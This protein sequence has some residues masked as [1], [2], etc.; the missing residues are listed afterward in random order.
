MK[1]MKEQRTRLQMTQKVFADKLNVSIGAVR[2]WEQTPGSKGYKT[3]SGLAV[4]AVE[5]LIK[6]E[7]TKEKK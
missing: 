6:L 7:I 2:S 1:T 5:M 3:P 4:R